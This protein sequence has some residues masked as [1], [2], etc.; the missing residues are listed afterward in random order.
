VG[1]KKGTTTITTF[2]IGGPSIF[3][4]LT[5]VGHGTPRMGHGQHIQT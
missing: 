5:R 2:S 4:S 1:N 3:P